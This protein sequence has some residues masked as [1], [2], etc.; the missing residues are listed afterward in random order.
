[1]ILKYLFIF[2]FFSIIGW[3]IEV[4][5]R[6]YHNKKFIN[7]GFLT[8]CVVPLYGVGAIIINL[9]CTAIL[10][11]NNTHKLILIFFVS[12]SVLTVLEFITGRIMIDLFNVKLWDYSKEKFNYKGIICLKFTLAWGVFALIYYKLLYPW[13]NPFAL[14]FISKNYAV[15]MLG[16][17]YGIFI[18][19]LCITIDLLHKMSKYAE[20]IKEVINFENLKIETIMEGSKKIWNKIYPYAIIN[21]YLKE[22]IKK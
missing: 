10:D 15:F 19:D 14:N 13:I 17:F 7:P 2:A 4:A 12:S 9:L 21:K 3:F 16:I 22:K 6:S 18:V 5:Y 11:I 1:M 8:G 20:K